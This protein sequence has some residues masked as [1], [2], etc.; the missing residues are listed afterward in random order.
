MKKDTRDMEIPGWGKSLRMSGT[1]V[2]YKGVKGGSNR[3]VT[4][5]YA[6]TQHGAQI[7][8]A[9][10]GGGAGMDY[11]KENSVPRQERS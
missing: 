2:Q 10:A 9:E 4:T 8:T 7:Q 1:W 11:V 5:K 3:R 6:G